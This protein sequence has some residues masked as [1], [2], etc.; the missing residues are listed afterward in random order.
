MQVLSE[1]MPES[2][3]LSGIRNACLL[4]DPKLRHQPTTMQQWQVKPF[5]A[6][7]HL[8]QVA[9]HRA[10]SNTRKQ[11]GAFPWQYRGVP[12]Y[13]WPSMLVVCGLARASWKGPLRTVV[14][15][16]WEGFLHPLQH[17]G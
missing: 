2:E 10:T 4:V 12:F 7:L 15:C 5:P 17:C 1:L 14:P 13:H 16:L 8:F 11:R 9:L 6:P 3:V